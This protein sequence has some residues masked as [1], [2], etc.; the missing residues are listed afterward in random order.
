[1]NTDLKNKK[2]KIL[3]TDFHMSWGGQTRLLFAIVK[4]LREKGHELYVATP[5]GSELG[6]RV[7][8]GKIATVINCK[9]KKGFSP[10]STFL[11]VLK[12][13][14][15][16]RTENIDIIHTHGS[17][18]SWTA[19]FALYKLKD[20]PKYVRTKH[21]IF[22]IRNTVFN[23]WLYRKSL[24]KII[25]VAKSVARNLEDIGWWD[26]E[27]IAIIPA[28]VDITRF[29]DSISGEKVRAEFG[30]RPEVKVIGIVSRI[31]P[32]KGHK[33]LIEAF[34][35]L[36][37]DK[38]NIELLICGA[39]KGQKELKKQAESLGVAEKVNFTGFREDVPEVLAA[40]DIFVLPS[41]SEGVATSLLEAMAMRKPVIATSV[42]GI[43]D[44]LFDGRTGLLVPPKNSSAIATQL[45]RFLS[46]ENFAKRL[47]NEGRDVIEKNFTPQ[48]L[49]EKTL[50]VYREVINE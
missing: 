19:A 5:P 14:K 24:D 3:H 18:D 49:V 36:K 8:E 37:H 35:S 15:L 33:Y 13:K 28:E 1:M 10:L 31:S 7:E 12:L 32:G 26:Q 50:K 30:I 23:R 27:S 46:D 39:G 48:Q 43:P 34:S 38:S 11:D 47:G 4:L 25:V 20:R 44:Y 21:N 29:D 40:M 41:L 2:L 9:F 42:G 22:P 45:R 17:Q 6:K 16:I